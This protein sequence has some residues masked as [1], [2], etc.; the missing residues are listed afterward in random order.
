M[1]VHRVLSV[2]RFTVCL[3]MYS[4]ETS[5]LHISKGGL[6]V[7]SQIADA[8]LADITACQGV[9]KHEK[10]ILK[11]NDSSFEMRACR[12]GEV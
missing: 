5:R 4:H 3:W 12:F 9:E 10:S 6:A 11:C 7:V 2:L 1:K 8:Y